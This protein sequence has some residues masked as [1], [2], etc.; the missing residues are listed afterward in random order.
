[1]SSER[2]RHKR[3]KVKIPVPFLIAGGSTAHNGVIVNL[4]FG[5]AFIRAALMVETGQKVLIQL[6][7]LADAP[8]IRGTVSERDGHAVDAGG[9]VR[10]AEGS[11]GFGV[12]FIELAR[13]HLQYLHSILASAGE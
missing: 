4:S 6:N 8:S 10:W 1:M 12:E 5:G 2:R 7:E 3:V 13:E 11:V 9:V